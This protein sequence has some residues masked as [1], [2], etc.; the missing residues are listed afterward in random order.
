MSYTINRADGFAEVLKSGLLLGGVLAVY[1]LPED[2]DKFKQF[3]IKTG[4]L[5]ALVLSVLA[6][7]KIGD[8]YFRKGFSHQAMYELRTGMGHKNILS[9]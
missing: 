8:I 2:T 3:F 7:L 9:E 4:I 1:S 6:T 5:T